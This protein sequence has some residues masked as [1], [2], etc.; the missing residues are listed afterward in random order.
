MP[1]ALGRC[2]LLFPLH[3][4][5]LF[6]GA[7]DLQRGPLH[8]AVQQLWSSGRPGHFQ[9][10]RQGRFN[11][12]NEAFIEHTLGDKAGT[13]TEQDNTCHERAE[14]VVVYAAPTYLLRHTSGI[15]VGLDL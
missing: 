14:Y 13:I 11:K 5:V 9:D 8:G 3:A 2:L 6:F 4:A 1:Q 10:K 7:Q 15:Q 12:G